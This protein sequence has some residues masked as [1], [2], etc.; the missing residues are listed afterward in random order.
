[1]SCQDVHTLL[2][3]QLD[4]ELTPDEEE[5][6]EQHLQSCDACQAARDDYQTI[7]GG[8]RALPREAPPEALREAIDKRIASEV[9]RRP[10]W[11][12]WTGGLAA[13]A[14]L[15]FLV[16]WLALQSG[17]PTSLA[18]LHLHPEGFLATAAASLPVS[19]ELRYSSAEHP[20]QTYRSEPLLGAYVAE[21]RTHFVLYVDGEETGA[22][23]IIVRVSYDF[24][25]DGS[26]DRVE[27]FADIDTDSEPGW[28]RFTDIAGG[29]QA[30][31]SYRDLTA[32]TVQVELWN[33]G[34]PHPAK[35]LCGRTQD[36]SGS[37]LVLP[38]DGLEPVPRTA[39]R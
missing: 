25:G 34:D 29:V 15:A 9:P 35:V 5:R 12:R 24:E 17:T 27:T 37:H 39:Q 13:A 3:A 28:Q 21:E 16:G 6:L 38:Y 20:D 23:D 31:G 2:S 33:A 22:D 4:G 10:L 18:R 32:G 8:L 30:E 19:R 36:T 26:V 14:A 1:M 11:V 7:G